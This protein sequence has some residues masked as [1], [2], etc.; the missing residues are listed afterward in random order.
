MANRLRGR[1]RF[2]L[3]VCAVAGALA[4]LLLPL[5]MTQLATVSLAGAH[6]AVLAAKDESPKIPTILHFGAKDAHI[7]LVEKLDLDLS[8]SKVVVGSG[9]SGIIFFRTVH[10]GDIAA[11]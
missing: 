8:G 2:I 11:N 5:L 10:T 7:P 6:L 1:A 3:V 4:L 9:R